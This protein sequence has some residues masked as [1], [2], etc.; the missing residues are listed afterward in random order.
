M[1]IGFLGAGAW[2]VALAS[3]LS[4]KGYSVLSWTGVGMSADV[5]NQER[6]HPKLKVAIP[7]E[8]L[9]FTDDMEKVLDHAE[10]LV[11]SVTSAGVRPVFHLVKKI[12]VPKVPIALTSKGIEQ[13]SGLILSDV[14]CEVLGEAVRPQVGALSGPSYA[15]EVIQGLPTSVVGSAYSDEAM[16]MICEAFTTSSFRVYPNK[17]MRGVAFGGALKNVIAI[18]CGAAEGLNYGYSARASLMTRGLHEMQKLATAFGCEKETLYGLSG[19]GDLCVT[20]S[21]MTSRNFLF[22]YLLSQGKGVEEAKEEIGMVVEGAY[23]TLSAR[24]LAQQ[25]GVSMPITEGVY[26]LVY[27]NFPIDEIVRQLMERT[28]KEE[29][30]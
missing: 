1:K 11:E 10:L 3:L 12:G 28:I 23:T 29:H 7:K 2:G 14:V 26:A 18:A 22:G 4:Q 19:M 6:F 21:A 25:S 13:N 30:L 8:N 15:S 27:K 17:D 16:E 5:L 20:C 24:Q 9:L